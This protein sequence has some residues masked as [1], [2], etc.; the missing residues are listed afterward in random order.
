MKPRSIQRFDQWKEA[1]LTIPKLLLLSRFTLGKPISATQ[2]EE[3]IIL[4]NGP[5]LKEFLQHHASFAANKAIFAVNNFVRTEA[6][7]QIKPHYYVLAATDFW[8]K[9]EKEGWQEERMRIFDEL[10]NRT[11]WPMVLMIPIMAKKH[12][13]WQD[14]IK[15]NSQIQIIY[16]N[17]TP[18]EGSPSFINFCLNRGWGMPRPHNVLV[19]TLSLALAMRFKKIYITGADHSWLKEVFVTDD[20]R[21]FLSQ[22]HFYDDQLQTATYTSK[23]R[24]MYAGPT[25]RERKIHEILQKWYY[26]FRSYWQLQDYAQ[27]IGCQIVNITPNSYIDAFER[28]SIDQLT[29]NGQ[30]TATKAP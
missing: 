20:N 12:Q 3:A 16:F 26:S 24:P 6:F 7:Q 11:Q 13:H 18:V 4:A 14:I 29:V 1:L 10:V 15:K 8:L 28:E 19:A 23:A 2:P 22:K 17:N 21:V 30:S 27:S 5:S 25:K 9:E